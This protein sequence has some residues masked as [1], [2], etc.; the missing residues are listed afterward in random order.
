MLGAAHRGCELL[1]GG[2]GPGVFDGP[3]DGPRAHGAKPSLEFERDPNGTVRRH[4]LV[5]QISHFV[6]LDPASEQNADYTEL[7][8][9]VVLEPTPYISVGDDREAGVFLAKG[10]DFGVRLISTRMVRVNDTSIDRFSD[11]HLIQC[12][13]R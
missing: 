9:I 3:R 4:G 10:F 12:M 8:Q 2:L 13:P 1:D 6:R 7:A 5:H 11:Q